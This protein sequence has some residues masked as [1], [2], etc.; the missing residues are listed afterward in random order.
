MNYNEILLNESHIPNNPL[1]IDIVNEVNNY[2]GYAYAEDINLND[3]L[4]INKVTLRVSHTRHYYGDPLDENLALYKMIS[5]ISP[6]ISALTY[7]PNQLEID[8]VVLDFFPI[9]VLNMFPDN[10]ERS[11]LDFTKHR[12]LSDEVTLGFPIDTFEPSVYIPSELEVV[13]TSEDDY[14]ILDDCVEYIEV[15]VKSYIRIRNGGISV[16]K[17]K[18]LLLALDNY[19][20]R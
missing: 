11:I 18:L 3:Y 20:G 1:R 10:V 17:H 14:D 19:Y 4:T 9:K 7:E 6:G 5:L 16:N 2:I 15:P 13:E 12:Q 8:A